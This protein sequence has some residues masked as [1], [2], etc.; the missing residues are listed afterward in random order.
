MPSRISH[1]RALFPP[2]AT[3]TLTVISFIKEHGPKLSGLLSLAG[4]L[5]RPETNR[6]IDLNFNTYGKRLNIPTLAGDTSITHLDEFLGLN[7]DNTW[8]GNINQIMS[9]YAS[10][11]VGN[12]SLADCSMQQTTAPLV[13]NELTKSSTPIIADNPLFTLTQAFLP[14]GVFMTEYLH[15]STEV[16]LP[17]RICYDSS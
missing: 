15:K 2:I 4:M 7:R 10:Y 1:N 17:P 12:T 3:L 11:F 14:E 13:T 8:F 16:E 6:D 5:Y 9:T